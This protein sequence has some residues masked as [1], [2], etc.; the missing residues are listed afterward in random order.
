LLALFTGIT[1]IAFAPILVR[2]SEVGPSATAGYR[3]LLALPAFLIWRSLENR[4]DESPVSLHA[5]LRLLI[6]TGFLFAGDLALWHWSI[7]FTSVANSTLFAN[8]AP[9][10]VTIGARI[11]F[12]ESITSRF[13]LGLGLCMTGAFMVAGSSLSLSLRHLWGDALGIMTAL[14]YGGYLLCGKKL[15]NAYSTGQVMLVSGCVAAPLLFL[16]AALSRESLVPQSPQGWWVLVAL[17]L[18]SQVGGQ[19]LIIYGF[20]HLPAGFSALSLMLQPALAALLAWV[21]LGETLVILQAFGGLVILIGIAAA[22][23]PQGTA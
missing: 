22:Y 21:L 14:F 18:L 17:A 3:I 5:G 7:R 19:A 2:L 4:F 23:R 8:L 1:G 20:K 12:G 10:V 9:L 13:L 11:I 15:R 6:L 16:V